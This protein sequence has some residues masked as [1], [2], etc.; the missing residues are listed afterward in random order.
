MATMTD[1]ETFMLD[2]GF[3]RIFRAW[4][5]RP[6]KSMTIHYTS[7]FIHE[8]IELPDKD[9]LIGFQEISFFEDLEIEEPNIKYERLSNMKLCYYPDDQREENWRCDYEEP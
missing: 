7:I 3:T 1:F 5:I 6:D 4:F 8:V 2:D 9:I